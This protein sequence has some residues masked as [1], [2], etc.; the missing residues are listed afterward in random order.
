MR[1]LLVALCLS[2]FVLPAYA[3][4]I[5]ATVTK[6]HLSKEDLVKIGEMVYHAKGKNTCLYCHGE[7]GHDGNQAG[8]ADLRH[9][10]TWRSYQALGGD[11]ALAANKEEFLK[12]META[13]VYLIRNGATTWNTRF[14]K[15][16]KDIHYD[17]SKVTVP[18]KANKYNNMMKG[19]TTGPMRKQLKKVQKWLAKQGKKVKLREAR[20]VA[21]V[22]ALEYV[23]TLDDGSEK[24]GV[25]NK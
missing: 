18:D 16:Y 8:A 6:L 7:G 9:P 4:D 13:L 14:A 1:T 24:G 2:W 25:F 17:W 23:K 10:R 19:L 12:K 5:M 21:A 20:D 15:K 3:G 11:E 22:A